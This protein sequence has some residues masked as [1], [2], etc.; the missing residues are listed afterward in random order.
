MHLFHLSRTRYAFAML[1]FG[2]CLQSGY[3]LS[4]TNS[5]PDFGSN[6][7]ILDPSMSAS[8]VQS[9]VDRIFSQQQSNQF[10]SNRYA[11]L[12]KPGTYNNTINV[13]F[14]TQL[15]GLGQTPDAVTINGGVQVDAAWFDRDATQNFWRGAEN[16]AV[17][18]SN[19][20]MK[21]A[22]AQASPL[23]RLHVRGSMV[24]DDNGWSSGGFISDSL[25][26]SEIN[27]GMQQQW[28]SRNSRWGGWKGSN[29]NIVFVGDDNA[30]SG[31][32]WPNQSYTVIEHTPVAREKPFLTIDKKGKYS[33]FV[34]KLTNGS[35]GITWGNGA[36][37]GQSIPI[38]KFYIAKAGL[39]TATTI[40]RA[41][42][43]GKHLLLTPGV[44]KLNDTLRVTTANTIV[45]GLGIATLQPISGLSA[46]EVGDVDGVK[47]AGILF[48]AGVINSSVLLQVGPT[49]S[50][51]SH[52]KNPTSLHDVFFRVGGAGVGNAT[53]S[54]RINSN[55]VIGDDLWLWRADHGDGIGWST[56][57]TTNG[58]EV[59]GDN[60]TI[61]GLAV[62]HYHQYQTVWNGNAGAVYF[63]Q[64][65]APYDVP[66]QASWMNGSV[67]GYASYKVADKVTSH[68][69]WGVG[70]YCFFDTN[71]DVKLH[72]AIEV[73]NDNIGLNGVMFHDVT[74]VSLGGTGEITHVIGGLGEAAN[75]SYQVIRLAK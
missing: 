64:S 28:L 70:V 55:N 40:N 25:I 34:P 20:T 49:G 69:A 63:Y 38:S 13:G 3:A 11:I 44:Y 48:D 15:L 1:I 7:V 19:G 61:Y 21:W 66:D 5:P 32:N 12:F 9:K 74:T 75:P 35:Q 23:R 45:L 24:L 50:N 27:S 53:V 62:E 43:K 58:L 10:G 73:P 33:V 47:L 4:S 57:T 51:V 16:L 22:V 29:W 30:P 36:A 18:P 71:P 65:E 59:N 68:Q 39:D 56:N 8:T 52:S 42:A 14:Y 6:V 72:S 2:M 54:L 41:L 31:F 37:A 46:M 17:I 67:N 60:V 26:D